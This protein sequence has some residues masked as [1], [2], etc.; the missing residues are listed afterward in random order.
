[1]D[2]PHCL[3]RFLLGVFYWISFDFGVIL[4]TF[5]RPSSSGEKKTIQQ[6]QIALKISKI[7]IFHLLYFDS[8]VLH[9]WV[10]AVLLWPLELLWRLSSCPKK[11]A[12]PSFKRL[13]PFEYTLRPA[14]ILPT[15]ISVPSVLPGISARQLTRMRPLSGT[16]STAFDVFRL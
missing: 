5:W 9:F 6:L 2:S 14:P 11:A 3:P 4:E 1:M 12:C 8:N 7:I 16:L 15:E 13:A 10:L